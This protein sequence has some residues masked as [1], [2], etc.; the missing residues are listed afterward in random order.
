MSGIY[1]HIPFCRKKCAYCNFFSVSSLKNKDQFLSALI[2][3][4]YLRKGYLNDDIIDTV[5]FGGGTP[6]VLSADE[7]TLIINKVQNSFKLSKNPEIT[8]EANPESIDAKFIEGLKRTKVNRLSIGIQSFFDEDLKYLGRIHNANQ[9]LKS[10]DLAI[11]GGFTNLSADLIYSIPGM[12][13]ERWQENLNTLYRLGIE[14][15]SAYSLTVEE[16]TILDNHIKKGKSKSFDE[17]V[18]LIQ[19]EILMD[20]AEKNGYE[21]YETSN[22]CRNSKYSLHNTSY[23]KGINYLGLGPSAHSYNGESRQWNISNITE[24]INSINNKIT[25]FELEVLSADQKYNEYI[26]TSLRTIWGCNAKYINDS[27]GKIYYEN[28]ICDSEKHLK[29]EYIFTEKDVYYLTRKGKFLTDLITS[30]LFI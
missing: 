25:P 9:A 29:N 19:F 6:S 7:I 28:F 1:I 17:E 18:S 24:Y 4:I 21:H 23:W 3:E 30:D 22:F 5:Y 10:L 15:F 2:E 11:K 14:H 13:D 20:F 8:L 16:G 27:F 12:T 26:L